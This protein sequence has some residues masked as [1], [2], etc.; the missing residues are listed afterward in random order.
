M[1]CQRD[2]ILP[3][4]A[5]TP[6]PLY[7]NLTGKLAQVKFARKLRPTLQSDLEEG[8]LLVQERGKWGEEGKLGVGDQSVPVVLKP[9][10]VGF[11]QS[12]LTSSSDQL[13]F[14]AAVL[15]NSKLT[16]SSDQLKLSFNLLSYSPYCLLMEIFRDFA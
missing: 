4:T 14:Q 12:S 10:L 2:L 8:N 1:V 15:I 13:K 7:L 11:T 3:G 9:P 5:K 16:S 6:F